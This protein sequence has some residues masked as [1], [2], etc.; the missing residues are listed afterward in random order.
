NAAERVMT[1]PV[2]RKRYPEVP[3]LFTGGS[4]LARQQQYKEADVV[5]QWLALI[6]ITEQVYFEGRSR[7]TF[8]NAIYA[9]EVFDKSKGTYLLVTSAFH[10]PR[11]V[12]VFQAQGWS[13]APY[14]VDYRVDQVS[15]PRSLW[16]NLSTLSIG[17]HEWLGLIAYRLSHRT[18]TFFPH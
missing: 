13:I 8:E 4:G 12:A 16:L 15:A 1:I 3:I 5:R 18:S 11:S 2:L 6:G 7:N 10:V 14:G 17:V 9:D